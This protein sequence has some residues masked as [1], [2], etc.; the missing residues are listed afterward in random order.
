[1]AV[2]S[3]TRRRVRSGDLTPTPFRGKG[4]VAAEEDPGRIGAD[5]AV[6]RWLLP[7]LSEYAASLGI[8]S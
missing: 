3:P 7:A 8:I 5:E 1:V 6:P 2:G 4:V